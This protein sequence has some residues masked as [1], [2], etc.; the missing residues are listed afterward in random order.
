MKKLI[1]TLIACCLLTANVLAVSYKGFVDSSFGL[2][3]EKN[4][5]NGEHTTG[6]YV[7]LSTTHGI[8]FA[9][10][11]FVGAGIGYN[12]REGHPDNTSGVQLMNVYGDIR[13]DG[14]RRCWGKSKKVSPF[15]D[16]KIGYQQMIQ[17]K[18]VFDVSQYLYGPE[19]NIRE[20]WAYSYLGGLF[21]KPT[22]GIRA[23][24]SQ[25]VGINFGLFCDV[26]NYIK[27]KPRKSRVWE[28]GNLTDEFITVI[29][30]KI[31]CTP[32]GISIGVDF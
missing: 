4:V 31:N 28:S 25:K 24:I 21:V 32:F 22:I 8:R 30:D 12:Y 1:F 10:Y 20:T 26:V 29:P 19:P 16:I 13:W 6:L 5:L 17:G 15:V 11:F 18:Y 7:G 3:I 27:L 9:K 23:K 2:A 14:Q